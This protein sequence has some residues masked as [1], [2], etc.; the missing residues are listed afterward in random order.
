MADIQPGTVIAGRY[1]LERRL[2]HGG[3]GSVWLGHHMQLD[4]PVA[5]KFMRP[6]LVQDPTARSRFEREAKAAAAIRSPHVVHI[7]DHGLDG[8]GS[9]R[10][11]P[12]SAEPSD[13]QRAVVEALT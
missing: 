12:C 8:W 11:A 10:R 4:A 13:M 6:S 3:M 5:V 2:S 9:A 1:R 7:Y